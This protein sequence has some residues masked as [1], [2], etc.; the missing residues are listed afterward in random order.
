[1]ES[2]VCIFKALKVYPNPVDLLVILQKSVPEEVLG[3]VY[4]MVSTEQHIAKMQNQQPA[5]SI[6]VVEELMT[7]E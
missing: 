5:G 3:L 2:A 7:V 4:A 6:Q 1:M